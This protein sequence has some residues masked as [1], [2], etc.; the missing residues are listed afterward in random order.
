MT[1]LVPAG[2]AAAPL[3]PAT[4]YRRG[5][6]VDCQQVAPSAG[7]PRCELCH[8][9]LGFPLTAALRRE[10]LIRSMTGP[11]PG[12]ALRAVAT[13][14]ADQLLAREQPESR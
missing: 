8:G 10:A 14:I 1:A 12:P 3:D 7:R 4:A 11:Y 5:L 9:L 6:C 13:I 2:S